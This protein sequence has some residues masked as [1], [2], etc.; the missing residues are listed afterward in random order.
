MS[1]QG[2]PAD[3]SHSPFLPARPDPGRDEPRD[4][5]GRAW[6]GCMRCRARFWSTNA[7]HRHCDHCRRRLSERDGGYG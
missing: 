2:A 3:V 4:R 7:G 5:S 1:R 6:R